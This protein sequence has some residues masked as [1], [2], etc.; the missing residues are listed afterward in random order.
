MDSKLDLQSPFTTKRN[1]DLLQA[2]GRALR[3]LC[4]NHPGL[5]TLRACSVLTALLSIGCVSDAAP[6]E[7]IAQVRSTRR[8]S[9]TTRKVG[10]NGRMD[11]TTQLLGSLT[12]LTEC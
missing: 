7:V 11:W 3:S 4:L 10:I 12:L 5:L 1:P 9:N 8:L 6:N 2:W